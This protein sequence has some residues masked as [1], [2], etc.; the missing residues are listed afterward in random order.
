VRG[1]RLPGGRAL[2]LVGEPSASLLD[3]PEVELDATY[4]E[5]DG[6]RLELLQYPS[7]G[8]SG[9]TEPRPMNAL[10]L[11]HLS[12]RVDD[13]AAAAAQLVALGARELPGTR[14]GNPK[15]GA[16]AVFLVCPRWGAHRAGRDARGSRR[17]LPGQ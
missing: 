8:H 11:T 3:L 9:S 12:F 6:F 5:R 7:P 2:H 15:L 16:G 17:G 14:V 1:P 4:L 13:L 10:R